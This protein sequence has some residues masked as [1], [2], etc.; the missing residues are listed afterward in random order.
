ELYKKIL[1]VPG[2]IVECGIFKGVS[3]MRFMMFM[4]LFETNN[5]R[6]IV[7]FDIFDL[8]PAT[9]YEEDKKELDLFVKETGG[10]KSITKED[11]EAYIKA[12]GHTNFELVKGDIL[13]TV[14]KYVEDH[15]ELRISLLN[16]D[17]DIYEPAKTIMDYLAPR[18]V[19]GG[20]IVFDDY[21][22]F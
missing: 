7:G 10:G 11:L 18:V 20:I 19:K 22:V 8:F 16:I 21:G 9:D 6:K 12:K 5:A 14:P 1:Q 17:T 4:N 3:F 15:P 2:D 13:K